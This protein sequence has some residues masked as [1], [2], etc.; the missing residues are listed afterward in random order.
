MSPRK[1]FSNQLL[2]GLPDDD[3]EALE[4]HLKPIKLTVRDMLDHADEPIRAIVFPL[5][6]IISLITREG[7][8][9]LEVGIIG[10]EGMTGAPVVLGV[11]SSPQETFV[12]VAGEGVQIGV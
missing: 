10:R 3:L 1:P 11:E 2:T 7:E 4:P 5:S 6:G 9:E 12:Q 8:Y